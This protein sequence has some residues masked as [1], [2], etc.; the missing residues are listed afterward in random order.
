MIKFFRRIRQQ[1]ISQNKFNKYVLYA[2]GE[3]ILVVIGIL[4]ALQINNHNE[5]RKLRISELNY[6]ANIKKDL[7]LNLRD[8][9]AIITRRESQIVSAKDVIDYHN[10]KPLEDLVD[11]NMK[12]IDVYLWKKFNL[13]NNAFNE[14]VGSGNLALISN[15]SIKNGL[16]NL[17]SI[18][19]NLKLTEEHFRYDTENLLYEPVFELLDMYPT[20]ESFSFHVSNGAQGIDKELPRKDFEALIKSKKHKNGMALAI[21]ELE[22]MRTTFEN[23]KSL[24]TA[25]ITLIEEEIEKG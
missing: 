2:I 7:K 11:F 13:N 22:A 4:I 17:E 8:L 15:D 14:L 20:V 21:Y 6:L 19:N 10:G 24:V 5:Q 9:E 16:L 12:C 3:I 18:N 1:L 25:L 23:M